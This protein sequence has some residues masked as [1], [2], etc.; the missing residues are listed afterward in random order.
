MNRPRNRP[1][2]ALTAFALEC[3]PLLAIPLW[4]VLLHDAG[5]TPNG[6]F[7]FALLLSVATGFG[8]VWSGSLAGGCACSAVRVMVL[9]FGLV[10]W[11][12]S[13]IGGADG[14]EVPVSSRVGLAWLAGLYTTTTLLCAVLA[15]HFAWRVAGGTRSVS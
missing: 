2:F 3:I 12:L 6:L 8:W 15:A 14:G 1:R 5:S 4:Y 7:F 13:W 11:I 10:V 9:G